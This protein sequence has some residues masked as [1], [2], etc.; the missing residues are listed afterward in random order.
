MAE[1]ATCKGYIARH[2]DEV[3]PVRSVCGSSTRVITSKDSDVASLH[4][5]HIKDS[6]KH[7]HKR[8]TEI[9]YVLEG[10]GTLEVGDE[11]IALT[12]GMT[13]LIEPGVPHRGSGDFKAA[14]V[15]VPP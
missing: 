15:S 3:E 13:V 12:P 2:I 7:Y 14:I 10:S 1:A 8:I 5:T 11:E 4:L 9:Y 6:Q